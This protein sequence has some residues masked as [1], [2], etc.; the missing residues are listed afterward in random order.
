MTSRQS[1][2]LLL[3]VCLLVVAPVLLLSPVTVRATNV[4]GIRFDDSVSVAGQELKL[5]GAGFRFKAIFK[6]YAA[7]LYLT[8]RCT[9]LPEVLAAGGA[10]RVRLV[11]L[12]DV[13]SE[14]FRQAFLDGIRKN[15]ERSERTRLATQLMRLNTLLGASAGLRNGDVLVADW[16]PGLGTVF[17]LNGQKFGDPLPDLA[18]FNAILKIWLG[19]KPVDV[20]L[21]RLMLGEIPDDSLRGNP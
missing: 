15:M 3:S 2:R 12:R 21:K 18:F 16:I 5:N 6:V 9:S 17:L 1:L 13:S 14:E 19:D 20:G 10:R 7:G 4:D 8:A 11:L